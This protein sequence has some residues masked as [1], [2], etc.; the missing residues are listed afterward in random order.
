MNRRPKSWVQPLARLRACF[1]ESSWM[2]DR[3]TFWIAALPC[4]CLFAGLTAAPLDP[5]KRH[6]SN[7]PAEHPTSELR[8]TVVQVVPGNGGPGVLPA[9]IVGAWVRIFAEEHRRYSLAGEARTGSEGRVTLGGLPQG[10]AWLVSEAPG[11]ARCSAELW[12]EAPTHRAEVALEEAHRLRVRVEDEEGAALAQ[13]TVLVTSGDTL[14][15]G[16]LT[17][18]QGHALHVRLGRPP[19]T[20][21]ASARG[22][23]SVTRRHVEGDTK[24]VLRRL[25][26]LRVHVLEPTGTPAVGAT[27]Y[28]VGT[29][30]W[31]ARRAETDQ[32]GVAS[33]AGLLD[34]SYDL[35][36][37]RRSLVSEVLIG[38]V[39]D[40]REDAEL[41]L[42]LLLGRHVAVLVVDGAGAS[43]RPVPNADVILSETGLSSFPLRGRTGPQGR[44][45]L[46]PI[47]PGFATVTARAPGFVPRFA[48]PVPET[49]SGPLQ[50]ALLRAATLRGEVVDHRGYPV[51]GASIEVVGTDTEG[52]PIAETPGLVAF[53][54]AHFAWS[55]SGPR[56]LVPAGELGVM[57][58]P[59]PG[60]PRPWQTMDWQQPS[61]APEVSDSIPFT[62][63]ASW[64]THASGRFVAHPVTPGRLRVIVRHRDY[65]ETASDTVSVGPGG[66][67]SV[68]V[69]LRPGGT[70]RGRVVDDRGYPV[71]GARLEVLPSHASSRWIT[72]SGDNGSFF[73]ENLPP[74]VMVTVARPEDPTR[75]VVR[76]RLLVKEAKEN[77]IELSLPA[78]RQEI[79]IVVKDEYGRPVQGAQ[80]RVV[81]LDPEVALRRTQFTAADGV[82]RVPDALGLKLEVSAEAVSLPRLVHALAAAPAAIDLVLKPGVVVTGR[83]TSL[84]GRR[85]VGGATV[86]LG[87][88]GQ[89]RQTTTDEHGMYR[90]TNVPPGPVGLLVSHPDYA[91]RELTAD[92]Q[93]TGRH[94]RP[95][96]LPP[97]DLEEGG[98]VEGEVVDAEGRPVFGARVAAGSAPAYLPMGAA[99]R[100]TT[101]TDGQGRFRLS[102]VSPGTVRLEAVSSAAGRGHAS[103]V[104]VQAGRTTSDVRIQLLPSTESDEPAGGGNVALTLGE[105]PDRTV[106]VVQVPE[107]S[108]AERAGIRVGDRVLAIDGERPSSLHRVRAMLAG[109][110]NSDVVL[111]LERSG[112]RRTVRL[113][114]EIVRR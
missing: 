34:G 75:P 87:F 19:W 78:I 91:D 67:A 85:G 71:A 63:P 27:V 50:I 80:V 28:I 3:V 106:A 42:Q 5:P 6:D 58:G 61:V 62:Q 18:D 45:T 52:L 16:A 69:V 23:E 56:P 47:V 21:K 13:A 74:E 12:L 37:T 33:I 26:S 57:P 25:G 90:V 41:T 70:L 44:V 110:T 64:D 38:Y 40:K 72:L 51:E 65:V 104:R 43:P 109:P 31:P 9:P 24:L 59:I 15:F 30:L 93:R 29:Q 32:Q 2:V 98:S 60:I 66:D 96:E 111:E 84:R 114:R 88:E 11:R 99:P 79:R 97:V 17:D 86:V 54:Q 102:R 7:A 68:R 14:P 49:L 10:A 48:V 81:S 35:K 94:D 77:E 55:L 1:R 101:L 46:G 95:L 39:L 83:I 107:G 8:V 113:T 108:E 89:R 4:L 92:V 22:Y 73:L 36:A 105:R 76:R 103:D 53:S 82:V 100:G 20:V 112:Q